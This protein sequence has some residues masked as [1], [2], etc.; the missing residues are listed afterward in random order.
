MQHQVQH[1]HASKLKSQT[2]ASLF[3]L[4]RAAAGAGHQQQA[5][6]V[7]GSRADSVRPSGVSVHKPGVMT[8]SAGPKQASIGMQYAQFHQRKVTANMSAAGSAA[9]MSSRA[10]FGGANKAFITGAAAPFAPSE[11]KSFQK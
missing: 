1:N 9:Q 5:S 10:S 6:S 4:A 2:G 3:G 7:A 11:R 8:T